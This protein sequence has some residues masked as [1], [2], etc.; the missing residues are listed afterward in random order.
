[1]LTEIQMLRYL[2]KV[3]LRLP[4]SW[5]QKK[6]VLKEIKQ[7]IQSY[8]FEGDY[9]SYRQICSRFGDPEQIALAYM[10]EMPP[11]ELLGKLSIKKTVVH[12]L[13]AAVI[14]ATAIWATVVTLSYLSFEKDMNGYT[15]IEIIE[16]T[17]SEID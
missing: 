12:I 11:E 14:A 7:S 5:K 9:I 2:V 1:M 8:V 13:L 6:P 10:T 4:G 17:R 15:T 3:A 16:I